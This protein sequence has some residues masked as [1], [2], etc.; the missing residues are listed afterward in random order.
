MKP[1]LVLSL[2]F[3]LAN[4]AEPPPPTPLRV[5]NGPLIATY[6]SK[7]N[8]KKPYIA[9]WFAP[10]EKPLPLLDDSPADHFHHHGLMLAIGAEGT[11]FWTEKDVPNAGTQQ[12]MEFAP[13]ASGDGFTQ[14]LRWLATDGSHLLDETRKVRVRIEGTGPQAIHWLDWQSELTPAPGRETVKLWGRHYFGLG[15]RLL[16]EWTG[17]GRFLWQDTQGQTVVRGDEKLTPGGWCAVS[18][19]IDGAPVTLVMLAHPANSR[20][21]RWFTMSDPFCYLSASYN[22]EEQPVTLAKGERWTLCHSLAALSAP[23]DAKVLEKL[24]RKWQADI[25]KIF[26]LPPTPSKP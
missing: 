2:T 11:D 9:Q 24:A 13:N 8:P 17:K 12:P 10:G 18:N 5:P 16:P 7:A 19:I 21:T 22:L 3:V 6:Q 4:A 26:P 20:P 25:P 1:L 15:L 14:K 23:A